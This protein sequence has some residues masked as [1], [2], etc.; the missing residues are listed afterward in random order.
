[1][2]R[3]KL[4]RTVSSLTAFAVLHLVMPANGYAAV[5][6]FP[7]ISPD[8]NTPGLNYFVIMVAAAMAFI[9]VALFGTWLACI[10]LVGVRT[11]TG[12]S[13]SKTLP[14]VGIVVLPLLVALVV[15]GTVFFGKLVGFFQ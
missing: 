13:K 1:M 14:G 10:A 12:S 5:K 6:G 11:F 8:W 2:F 15:S 3:T 4:N 9:I 7:K